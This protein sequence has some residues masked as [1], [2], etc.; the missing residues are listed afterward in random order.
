ME[1]CP[2]G[3]EM[4]TLRVGHGAL[5]KV[6]LASMC[7]LEAFNHRLSSHGALVIH[8][9]TSSVMPHRAI[10]WGPLD[11]NFDLPSYP[12]WTNCEIHCDVA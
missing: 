4:H 9:V 6:A 11:A 10:D 1:E 8:F 3:L 7:H 2:E 5:L 12:V